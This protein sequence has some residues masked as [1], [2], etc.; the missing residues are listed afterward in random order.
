[1]LQNQR[2]ASFTYRQAGERALSNVIGRVHPIFFVGNAPMGH[3]P[4][5]PSG[6]SHMAYL[7]QVHESPVH[8]FTQL[9]TV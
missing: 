3:L 8:F 2:V 6:K 1:M 4:S 9:H 5:I 7:G